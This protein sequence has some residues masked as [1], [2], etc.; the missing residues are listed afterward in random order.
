[1]KILKNKEKNNIICKFKKHEIKSKHI[2]KLQEI[3][4]KNQQC[5]MAINMDKINKI[6]PVFYS[7]A[8]NNKVSFFNVD[9][10]IISCLSVTGLLNNIRLFNSEEDYLKNKRQ[11]LKRQFRIV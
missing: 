1:M 2:K 4:V 8:K 6:S 5:D 7:F 10:D 3:L 9:N 11:L